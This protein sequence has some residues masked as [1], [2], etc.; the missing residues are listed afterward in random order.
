MGTK[1]KIFIGSFV[2]LIACALTMIANYPKIYSPYSFAVVIPVLFVSDTGINKLLMYVFVAIPTVTLYLI[3][4]LFFINKTFKIS[5]PT[6]ALSTLLI[7]AS[8]IFNISSYKYGI[9]YQG[10]LHTIL[11][12]GYN[13]IFL[14]ALAFIFKSNKIN[15][16]LTNCLGFNILLFSWVGWCAFPWLGELI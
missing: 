10:Y 6:I 16:T 3:W 13:I 7:I 8:V 12:Y 4:S 9:E 14:A 2:V 11:M 1:S 15:P 5:K